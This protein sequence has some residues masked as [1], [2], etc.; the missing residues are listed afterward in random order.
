M[1][2]CLLLASAISQ[3][4]MSDIQ[5]LATNNTAFMLKLLYYSGRDINDLGKYESCIS[6]SEANY[7]LLT[8]K[9]DAVYA[10]LG[11]CVPRSCSK[12]ELASFLVSSIEK[13]GLENQMATS[14]VAVYFPEE[15]SAMP[16]PFSAQLSLLIIAIPLLLSIIGTII[17][18]DSFNL[19]TKQ[20]ALVD[21]LK[22]FS[23]QKNFAKLVSIPE[24]RD[25]LS[26]I[27]GLRVICLFNIV[28]YHTFNTFPTSAFGEVN[29][30]RDSYQD[31]TH[32]VYM[33]LRASVNIFFIISGFLLSYLTLPEINK[34]KDKYSW[35]M[36][37][38]R[39]LLRLTP[40]YYIT[41]IIAVFLLRYIG[42]GPQWPIHELKTYEGCRDYWWSNFLYLQDLV[43]Y[44]KFPCMQ[45]SWYVANDLHFF[46]ISPFI[47]VAYYKNK[48]WGYLTCAGLAFINFMYVGLVSQYYEFTPRYYG[49]WT[50]WMQSALI[51]WKPQ[52]RISSFL[53]GIVIGF[54]YRSHVNSR[55]SQLIE[56]SV[57]YQPEIEDCKSFADKFEEL[58]LSITS[59]K[60]LRTLF[61]ILGVFLMLGSELLQNQL[62]KYGDDYWTQSFKSFFL[63]MQH[64]M[65]SIGFSFFFLPMLLGY[66]VNFS[67]ILSIGVFFPLA[68]LTFGAY[69]VHLMVLN[70]YIFGKY[71]RTVIGDFDVVITGISAF[72]ISMIISMI[73]SLTVEI[74]L[75]TLER[76]FIPH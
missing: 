22:E 24:K 35:K 62:D 44:S 43:P 12:D 3:S 53:V 27:N 71:Q 41:L 69:L 75:L 38:T 76:K 54:L 30:V 1:W 61:Y 72:V 40:V 47:L 21:I 33:I 8:V 6:N 15:Y 25:T 65:F 16:L 46:M 26:C 29:L 10:Y 36:F 55:P 7:A 73:I 2:I 52:A 11:V 14:G 70:V 58:C 4:C 63:S 42:S 51:Y 49:G 9:Y 39:R 13:A 60:T 32:K 17:S 20:Y 74:P 68:K 37:I 5:H 23:L 34:Q 64:F 57:N 50:N 45:W 66:C 56:I 48:L 19:I 18:N 28:I 67:R 59:N 31:L